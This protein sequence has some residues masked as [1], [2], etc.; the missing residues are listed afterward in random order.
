[1]AI[2]CSGSI[3][4]QSCNKSK[5]SAEGSSIYAN[6][7]A[8]ELTPEH[9]VFMLKFTYANFNNSA[10]RSDIDSILDAADNDAAKVAYDEAIDKFVN[11]GT[12]SSRWKEYARSA[13][14]AGVGTTGDGNDENRFPEN[15]WAKVLQSGDSIDEFF[16]ADYAVD[17]DGNE[18]SQEYTGGPVAADGV[19]AGYLTTE[20][21]VDAYINQF[22]FKATREALGFGLCVT[23]PNS[24]IPLYEW[25]EEEINPTYT[26]SGGITCYSCH[27]NMNPVR[28][29]W[30]NFIFN[31]NYLA[32]TTQ[33][34]D[35]Y[36]M[37]ANNGGGA[38]LEPLDP[39]TGLPLLETTAE[40]TKY[41]LTNDGAIVSS[42]RILA[43]EITKNPQFS[44]CMVERFLSVIF[45]IEEGHPGQNYIVPNNFSGNE[46][47]VDFINEMTTK[48]NELDQKPKDFFKFLLKD[49]RYLILAVNP[50]DLGD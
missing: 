28:F 34:N 42:P 16:L 30:H 2:I 25:S 7:T 48:F 31:G 1:M 40:A 33:G 49:K 3:S 32:N 44:K 26:E 38:T 9:L 18:V 20:I 45:N 46:A 41:K 29:A 21:W 4:I 12:M 24:K 15:L 39:G 8:I 27:K 37:E 10:P 47:Q 50:D 36:N 5:V 11:N 22:K 19:F 17:D 14:G 13:L 6:P 35:Q 43:Q 23:F